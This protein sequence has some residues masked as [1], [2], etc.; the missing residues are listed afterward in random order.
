MNENSNKKNV[1]TATAHEAVDYYN[2]D[3]QLVQHF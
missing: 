2:E 1:H 3:G